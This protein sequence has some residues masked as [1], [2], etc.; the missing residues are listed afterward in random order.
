[1]GRSCVIKT[2]LAGLSE[3]RFSQA[4]R[5]ATR[6]WSSTESTRT[7]KGPHLGYFNVP[8]EYPG[9]V[10]VMKSAAYVVSQ[11]G[12]EIG[13]AGSRAERRFSAPNPASSSSYLTC[14]MSHEQ[15]VLFHVHSLGCACIQA[16]SDVIFFIL[17]AINS[18]SAHL[19]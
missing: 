9:G 12:L 6:P 8:W 3:R 5:G 13:L 17:Q 7:C 15:S 11:R 14:F 2:T 1:M 18:R 4:L 10:V 19:R 16:K